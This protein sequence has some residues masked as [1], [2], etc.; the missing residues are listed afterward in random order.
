MRGGPAD[1]A[2]R[3]TAQPLTAAR[4]PPS[5]SL[6][7]A[8][9][10]PPRVRCRYIVDK[11]LQE[12]RSIVVKAEGEARSAELIGSSIKENPG[13][14]QLRRIDAAREIS[15]TIS[16]SANKVYLTADSLLLNLS[17]KHDDG[18]ALEAKK[19]GFFGGK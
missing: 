14:L 5:L 7:A 16:N 15:A 9:R 18:G 11:A 3:T 17:D 8:A 2:P 6:G 19:G 12:K 4:V 10:A 13:F 1:V